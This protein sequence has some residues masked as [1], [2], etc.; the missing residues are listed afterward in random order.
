[1]SRIWSMWGGLLFLWAQQPFEG[2]LTYTTKIEG[3][4]A[5][6]MGEMLKSQ[7]PEKMT[8]FYRGTKARSEVGDKVMIT[9]P[10]AGFVYLLS[11]SLKTYQK[12]PLHPPKETEQQ[13]KITKTK[14]KTKILGYPVEQYLVD[15][16]TEQ[17]V[18]KME[19]WATPDLKVPE[20]TQR[21]NNLT[22]GVKVEGLP[23][24]IS[25]DVPGVD[26]KIT[27]LATQLR[28]ERPDESLF[29]IPEG[30]VEEEVSL[31]GIQK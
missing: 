21:L 3:A 17:G 18:I 10:E 25:M 15:L 31:E 22:R 4:M 13:P 9:D 20:T 14:N 11:P 28:R 5:A 27:F 7:L 29:R 19:I 24:R 6:Q 23:L 30:Y 1:M 12:V 16:N 2:T 8:L 26:L